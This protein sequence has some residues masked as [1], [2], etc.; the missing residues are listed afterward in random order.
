VNFPINKRGKTCP[1]VVP[2]QEQE[3]RPHKQVN[4]SPANNARINLNITKKCF[5][6]GKFSKKTFGATSSRIVFG[7][8]VKPLSKKIRFRPKNAPPCY[9][10][11]NRN[12]SYAF[13][14]RGHE[15]K[16][17]PDPYESLET[18]LAYGASHI[19]YRKHGD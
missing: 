4:V 9:Q 10:D 3:P 7:M 6:T 1:P 2:T 5:R 11:E 19:Y 12:E 17:I 15:W 13:V 16:N 8:Q 18:F 14:L